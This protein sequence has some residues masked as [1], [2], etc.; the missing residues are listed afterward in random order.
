V[1]ARL[2][3]EVLAVI[4][5]GDVPMPRPTPTA[6]LINDL[7]RE[8]FSYTGAHV[9]STV[10]FT[11]ITRV[12]S[13]HRQGTLTPWRHLIWRRGMQALTKPSSAV[14]LRLRKMLAVV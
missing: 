8:Y 14:M 9:A 5:R 4:Q 7:I 11:K 1:K 13:S 10:L 6:L 12:A 2:H 3:S